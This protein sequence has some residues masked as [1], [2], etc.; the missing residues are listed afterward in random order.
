MVDNAKA[1]KPY[2]FFGAFTPLSF[3]RLDSKSACNPI[4]GHLLLY[5]KLLTFVIYPLDAVQIGLRI[6]RWLCLIRD[7][8]VI[9]EC[10]KARRMKIVAPMVLPVGQII[11]AQMCDPVSCLSPIKAQFLLKRRAPKNSFRKPVQSHH[12]SYGLR[13]KFSCFVLSEI[14]LLFPRPASLEG[15]IAVVTDVECGMR[16]ACRCCSGL[17]SPTN[18]TGAHGQVARS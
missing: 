13:A 11:W 6:H 14:M 18:N 10:A 1:E 12:P 16:W 3:P 17:I 4:E 9:L 8:G 15:R 5:Q 7:D 2:A